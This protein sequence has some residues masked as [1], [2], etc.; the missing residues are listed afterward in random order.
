MGEHSQETLISSIFSSNGAQRY[1]VN[2]SEYHGSFYC[3]NSGGI[4]FFKGPLSYADSWAYC[5][6]HDS[7]LG[8]FYHYFQIIYFLNNIF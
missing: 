6:N 1:F 3:R 2:E 8:E 4:S 7:I 5:Q